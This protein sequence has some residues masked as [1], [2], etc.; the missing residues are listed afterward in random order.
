MQTVAQVHSS[1]CSLSLY[2]AKLLWQIRRFCMPTLNCWSENS[3]GFSQLLAQACAFDDNE[4][5]PELCA[6]FSQTWHGRALLQGP[7]G[8]DRVHLIIYWHVSLQDP[9]NIQTAMCIDK[10]SFWAS[11]D[12]VLIKFIITANHNPSADSS[13]VSIC[14]FWE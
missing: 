3:A 5:I 13:I 9:F 12:T 10:L 8:H 14:F 6:Q 2:Y 7:Y 1:C 4:L 11:I